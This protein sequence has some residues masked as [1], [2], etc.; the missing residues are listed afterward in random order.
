MGKGGEEKRTGKGK[1]NGGRQGGWGSEGRE[2]R[3][4]RGGQHYSQN[5]LITLSH[6]DM[7]RDNNFQN[8]N[9]LLR[10]FRQ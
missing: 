1:E 4:G 6:V 2:V 7:F 10:S 3:G 5:C 9:S 8:N